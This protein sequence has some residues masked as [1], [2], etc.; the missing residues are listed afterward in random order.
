MFYA[1]ILI[2][3]PGSGKSTYAKYKKETLQDRDVMII[4]L[5]PGNM[6]TGFDY[7][8]KNESKDIATNVKNNE[9]TVN[10]AD[11]NKNKN[12]EKA[13]DNKQAINNDGTQSINNDDT[14][15]VNNNNTQ[16]IN[17][18]SKQCDTKNVRTEKYTFDYDI[19]SISNTKDYMQKNDLGPHFSVKCI[20]KNFLDDFESFKEIFANKETAYLIIDF[21]GQIE[22]LISDDTLKRFTKNLMNIGFYPVAVNLVDIVFFLDKQILLSTYLMSTIAMVLLELPQVLVASKCDNLKKFG[23]DNL[24]DILTGKNIENLIVEGIEPTKKKYYKSIIE[25]ID[26]EGLLNFEI[27]DYDNVEAMMY[28]QLVIDQSSGYFYNEDPLYEPICKDDIINK[29]IN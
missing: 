23:S 28:L 7:D 11:K 6:N 18:D 27:L 17:N 3:P 19:K 10:S 14:R 25:L 29:Y 5:D 20:L 21:P 26:N 9:K 22:F 12:E 4:N 13:K 24:E 8:I 16:V 1:E 15:V 2:G